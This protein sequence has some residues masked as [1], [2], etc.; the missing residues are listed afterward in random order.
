VWQQRHSN[1]TGAQLK[2]NE[3]VDGQVSRRHSAEHVLLIRMTQ[4]QIRPEVIFVCSC[5]PSLFS[6]LSLSLF[7]FLQEAKPQVTT[8]TTVKQSTTIVRGHSAYFV[9]C[10]SRYIFNT[11]L[12]QTAL[13]II[14]FYIAKM[15]K[16][17]EI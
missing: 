10:Q 14:V 17:T 1:T 11:P 6:V 8:A 15:N 12:S 2:V 5:S 3:I 4:C 7:L 16:S 9:E 13:N